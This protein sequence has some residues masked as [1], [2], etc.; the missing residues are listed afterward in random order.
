MISLRISEIKTHIFEHCGF[1]Y[2][3]SK[4]KKKIILVIFFRIK[5][6]FFL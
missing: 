2:D 3:F 4:K 1:K 5:K 6:L